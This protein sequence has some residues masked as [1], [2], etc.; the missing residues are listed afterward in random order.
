ME[1]SAGGGIYDMEDRFALLIDADN[2]SAKYIQPILDE[3][4]KYGKVTYKRI[5]GDWTK[6]NNASWKEELLQNSIT[7]IQ[8]FSYTH[9]KNATDSAMII[10]AM[11]MLYTSDLEGFCLVSSD[12]DFTRLASRLRESGKT[13]IGMGE[14]KTPSPFRKACDIFTELE[15]LL[16]D[17]T[18]DKDERE[19]KNTTHH[20]HGK[21]QKKRTAVSK[22]QVEEAVVKIITENQNDDRETGLGEVGS[23]LV[24]LYP[25][26]DV[27]RYGYSLL[28]KFLETLP[29]LNLIQEGTKV[30]VTLYEDKSRKEMLEEYILQ[31]IQ[32]GGKYGIALSSLGNRIRV[33][34][35]DFKVRDYGFSQFKQYIQSFPDVEIVDDGE[36]TRAVYIRET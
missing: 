20:I 30:S 29:K 18:M 15:L 24:K 14:D 28:S 27:R 32:A 35:G 5:Y 23:R 36:R 21:E 11:D 3:L 10:D 6:T 26:F 31:Q 1:K 13:V 2:V 4:S 19:E 17:S 22:E 9:G 33:K 25:D 16:E 12:S 34:F 8:Q 7:P